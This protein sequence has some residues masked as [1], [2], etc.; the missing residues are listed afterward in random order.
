M[1]DL[2]KIL[3]TG[4]VT[5][6]GGFSIHSASQLFLK[7][8]ID[9]LQNYRLHRSEAVTLLSFYSNM[10]DSRLCE[11]DSQ[12]YRERYYKAQDE[13]RMCMANVKASYYSISPRWLAV[14]FG[15]IPRQAKFREAANNLLTLSFLGSF[16]TD[17]DSASKGLDLARS[18]V[19]MLGAE[20]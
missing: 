16:R 12:E 1:E 14:A 17:A 2:D 18:T 8:F 5:I 3:L 4:A 9:P 15:A 13:I 10:L 7:L 19:R 20:W 11:N 6:L